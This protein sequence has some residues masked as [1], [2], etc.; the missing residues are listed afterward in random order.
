MEILHQSDVNNCHCLREYM[1]QSYTSTHI[2]TT[3]KN[4]SYMFIC[5]SLYIHMCVCICVCLC[6]CARES[7]CVELFG[8]SFQSICLSSMYPAVPNVTSIGYTVLIYIDNE[9]E[10]TF[11]LIRE[12]TI[13][14]VGI[15]VCTHTPLILFI[16]LCHSE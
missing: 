7:V 15:F 16:F 2:C 4:Q 3:I 12:Q 8:I 6:I 14:L 1:N 10:G 11:P 13:C 9:S 5:L